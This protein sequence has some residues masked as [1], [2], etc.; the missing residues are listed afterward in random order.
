MATLY[1]TEF[2]ALEKASLPVAIQPPIAEQTVAI[3]GSSAASSPFNVSTGLVRL[4][5]DSIC[6]IEINNSPTATASKA[7]L[8]ANTTEYFVV[9]PGHSLAV[10]SNS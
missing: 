4:H 9:Q 8:A 10:I 3:G 6:S 5:T 2:P 1:V 7:R